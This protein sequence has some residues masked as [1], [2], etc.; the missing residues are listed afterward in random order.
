[1][2]LKTTRPRYLPPKVTGA[3]VLW[4]KAQR[5]TLSISNPLVEVTLMLRE[6]NCESVRDVIFVLVRDRRHIL[7]FS[8]LSP[9]E[10]DT[11]DLRG[12]SFAGDYVTN[13]WDI[14]RFLMKITGYCFTM[15]Q[16][17]D[18]TQCWVRDDCVVHWG[19]PS[20]LS[21][22]CSAGVVYS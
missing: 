15:V 4:E 1:M 20:H 21:C 7:M 10:E 12:A 5:T 14:I 13:P 19:K 6:L 11:F 17:R 3:R 2:S 16:E 8:S 9:M 18:N 22:R